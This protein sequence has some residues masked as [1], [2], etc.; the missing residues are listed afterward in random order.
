MLRS[1][2]VQVRNRAP[3]YFAQ[4]MKDDRE[5]KSCTAYITDAVDK[6]ERA[7][8]KAKASKRATDSK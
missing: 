7:N 2:A 3:D 5:L 8:T 6:E 4:N 1:I